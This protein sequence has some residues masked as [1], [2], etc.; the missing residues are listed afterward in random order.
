[1]SASANYRHPPCLIITPNHAPVAADSA[2]GRKG[3]RSHTQF[4]TNSFYGHNA[5][6]FGTFLVRPA[7]LPYGKRGFRAAI[8]KI[9]RPQPPAAAL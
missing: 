6:F 8:C 2:A 4:N 9:A 3:W 7:L 1:M 5:A